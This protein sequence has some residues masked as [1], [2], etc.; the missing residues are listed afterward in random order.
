MWVA[1]IM[2]GK[3]RGKSF[4]SLKKPTDCTWSWSKILKTREA[5]WGQIE[6]DIGNGVSI[7]S[8]YWH[9][10]GPLAKKYG[11]NILK[12]S[13]IPFLQYGLSKHSRDRYSRNAFLRTK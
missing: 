6:H 9:H 7:R 4:W 8:D 1:W 3:L 2:A 5:I 11:V 10:H 13:G 12:K